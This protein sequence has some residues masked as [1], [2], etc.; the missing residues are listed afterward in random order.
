MANETI[1]VTGTQKTL[2]ANGA[3]IANNAV[4]MAD[5]APYDIFADSPGY[6]DA[7]FVL[8]LTFAVAPTEGTAVVLLARPLDID[9]TVDAEVP[10]ATRPTVYIGS[11]IVNNVTT[12]Q[13][14][15]IIAEDVPWDAEYYLHNSGTGQTLSA[16]WTLKVTPY[17]TAPAP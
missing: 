12:P 11:A 14:H 4:G 10:E 7:K 15:E 9:G 3:A 17:T 1:I 16:G 6:S 5:D 13:Y 2:E 8:G